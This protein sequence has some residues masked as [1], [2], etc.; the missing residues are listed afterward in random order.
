MGIFQNI[1]NKL[2]IGGVKIAIEVPAE[3][4]KEAGVVQGKFTLTTKSDQ[5][6]SGM[7]VSLVEKY[8]TG[9][10]DDKITKEFTL[11]SQKFEVPFEIKTGETQVYD[12]DFPF[13]ILKSKNDALTDK[14]GA[15]VA[16]GK[17]GKFSKNE[18]SEYVVD[19]SVDV[20]SAALDPTEE[21]DVQLI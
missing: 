17:L 9:R 7:K 18:K 20:K 13:N 1:K 15:L 19:V 14:G 10:G 12:F 6:I 21:V 5:E 16:I 2:G 8:T 3:I 4:S 11:G